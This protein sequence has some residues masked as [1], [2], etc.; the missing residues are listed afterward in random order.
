MKRALLAGIGLASLVGAGPALAGN[1]VLTGHDDDLHAGGSTGTEASAA[2]ASSL[3]FVR[4][5]S[6]LPVLTFDSGSELTSALTA[7]GIAF[8]NVNPNTVSAVTDALFNNALYSAFAVA[9]ESSC[10]GCDNSPTGLANIATH[11]G[12]IASFFNAGGGIYGL[13]GAADLN[14]YAYVPEAASNAGGSPPSSGYVQTAAG[15][16]VGIN[17]VN[18]NATHNFFAEPGTS[19]LA[20]AFQV[21]ER[22]GD[23]STGTPETI[24]LG[25]GTISGGT[26]TTGGGGDATAVP[27]PASL[28][29]LGAGLAGL[30]AIR[31]KAKR[32]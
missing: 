18:G 28:T 8:T 32:A 2:I 16:A 26:I 20:S 7:L 29:L 27:E 11:S 17:A 25:A 31:R 23:P 15:A 4:A 19:G 21:F 6:S 10:G 3:S 12:A 5:G 13:A 1:I 9:S 22:L 30:G 14:A 24:G